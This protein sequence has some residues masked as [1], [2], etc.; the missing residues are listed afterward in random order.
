MLKQLTLLA[1]VIGLLGASASAKVIKQPAYDFRKSGMLK[2]T[3]V[4]RAKDA[5]RLTF[6]AKYKPK[7]YMSVSP[8]ELTITMPDDTVGIVPLKIEGDMAFGQ[9]YV[10][11]E[12]GEAS[13]IVTYP[14]LPKSAKKIDI[15]VKAGWPGIYGLDLSGKKKQDKGEKAVKP[16]PYHPIK[17]IFA[18]DTITVSG[19]IAGYD[20]RSGIQVMELDIKDN[21]LGKS[22]PVAF[23]IK[24]DGS[25]SRRFYLPMAQLTDFLV[26]GYDMAFDVYLEP[27]NDLEILIDYDRMIEQ[28]ASGAPIASAVT[29][30]GSLGELNNEINGCETSVKPMAFTLSDV[31][32][33]EAKQRLNSNYASAMTGI[34]AYISDKKVSP[35]A[36]GILRNAALAKHTEELLSYADYNSPVKLL[37]E[38]FYSDFL[39]EAFSADSTILAAQPHFLLN[40]LAFSNMLPE[41]RQEI[42]VNILRRALDFTREAGV[43]LNNEEKK[44]I[45]N[46]ADFES[47]DSIQE[48]LSSD[49][50]RGIVAIYNA[51]DRAGKVDALTEFNKTLPP[52]AFGKAET[53]RQFIQRISGSEE[54]PLLWQF[55]VT[56]AAGRYGLQ[57]MVEEMVP[58][59]GITNQYLIDHVTE[60]AKPK[61]GVRQ[62]PDTQAGAIMRNIIEPYRGKYLLIDFWDIYC[63]PC[64][65]GIED[66]QAR[67]ERHRGNPG[68][69]ILFIASEKGSPIDK[70]NA[71]VEKH[72]KGE[73][74]R[75]LPEE[76]ITLIRELFEFNGIPRYILFNPD[77]EIVSS[78]YSNHEFWELLKEKGII[79]EPADN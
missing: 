15:G 12:S 25:F 67:R 9:N 6:R 29:F 43:E 37:P 57:E 42:N 16:T 39:K 5:T 79:N 1:A 54:L 75:R 49:F 40:R 52:I 60:A 58:E 62:L 38:G 18:S 70:Y 77:G 66:N 11:P 64:R 69:A 51:A 20:P 17:T 23:P 33:E 13:F 47:P 50:L 78:D 59:H 8:E 72:L 28:A 32:P 19:R 63:G 74:L 2:V 36:A 65:A 26:K 53:N 71:Y 48:C 73:H 31:Q 4:D 24:A 68:F 76:Q 34:E 44:M 27:Q 45:A 14:A 3:E 7:W 10:M 21:A 30:G 55:A 35:K 22:I 61:P 46:I 41:R 56:A